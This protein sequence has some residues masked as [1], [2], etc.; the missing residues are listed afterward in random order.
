MW[1]DHFQKQSQAVAVTSLTAEVTKEILRSIQRKN[2]A[3]ALPIYG[4]I[5]NY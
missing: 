3:M 4:G 2:A 1:Q 5:N